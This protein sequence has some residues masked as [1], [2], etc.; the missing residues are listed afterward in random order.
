[1]YVW[2]IKYHDSHFSRNLGMLQDPLVSIAVPIRSDCIAFWVL[3][4]SELGPSRSGSRL[5]A[6]VFCHASVVRVAGACCQMWP[7]DRQSDKPALSSWY[8]IV[9]QH[10]SQKNDFFYQLHVFHLSFWWKGQ[11]CGANVCTCVWISADLICAFASEGTY[12]WS[13]GVCRHSW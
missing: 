13:N 10:L 1:M 6:L 8:E 4:H 2:D 11:V 3:K 5:P 9:D 7:A 12:N